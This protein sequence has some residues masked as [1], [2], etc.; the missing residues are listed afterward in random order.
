M[1]SMLL[2]M[3]KEPVSKFAR[4]VKAVADAREENGGEAPV[5]APA[6]EKVEEAA[7]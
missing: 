6:E 5:E 2:G 4:V 3:L 7:E 1:Y